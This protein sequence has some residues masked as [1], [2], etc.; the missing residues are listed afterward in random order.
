MADPRVGLG[1]ISA[2]IGFLVA[3]FLGMIGGHW[4]VLPLPMAAVSL[5]LVFNLRGGPLRQPL[6]I[7]QAVFLGLVSLPLMLN[8]SG[9]VTLIGCLA[10]VAA[11]FYKE[12][13]P[14]A[15]MPAWL[16]T[17]RVRRRRM[18][19]VRP[20]TSASAA[21]PGPEPASGAAVDG[22]EVRE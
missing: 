4:W 9:V 11:I 19:R 22:T 20:R 7:V 14:D 12:P 2:G 13:T 3:L 5:M 1:G 6:M 15:P 17:R 16:E 18:R 10:A 21:A 8:G